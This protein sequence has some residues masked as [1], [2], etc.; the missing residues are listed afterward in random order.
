MEPAGKFQGASVWQ[1]ASRVPCLR[2]NLNLSDFFREL[3]SN[4]KL[5]STAL[6]HKI[7]PAVKFQ[8]AKSLSSTTPAHKIKPGRVIRRCIGRAALG[9]SLRTWDNVLL[10]S[11]DFVTARKDLHRFYKRTWCGENIGNY[12]GHFSAQHPRNIRLLIPN[13]WPSISVSRL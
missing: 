1:K 9:S 13:M 10:F 4:K 8:G 7:E 12:H 5:S 6:A 3:F 11:C 2:T